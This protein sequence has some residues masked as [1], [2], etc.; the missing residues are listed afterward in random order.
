[1]KYLAAF[2]L[3]PAMSIQEVP[4]KPPAPPRAP[5]VIPAEDFDK[6]IELIA[7]ARI[8][9]NEAIAL[10]DVWRARAKACEGKR[11]I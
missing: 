3:L 2:V 9:E 7:S 8:G 11:Q 5:V 10:A 4:P 6:L 1:M